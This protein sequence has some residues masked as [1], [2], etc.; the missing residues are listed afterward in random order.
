MDDKRLI[1]KKEWKIMKSSD[2]IYDGGTEN[3]SGS[4]SENSGSSGNPSTPGEDIVYD[5]GEEV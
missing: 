3:G 1:G 4:D 5:G 2:L